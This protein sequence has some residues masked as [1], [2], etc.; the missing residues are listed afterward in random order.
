MSVKSH[1]TSGASVQTNSAQNQADHV[2]DGDSF[3]GG[4][5]TDLVE[6]TLYDDY[7]RLDGESSTHEYLLKCR[8]KLMVKVSEFKNKINEK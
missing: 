7:R 3:M 8:R 5:D 4:V 6:M 1:L 2:C